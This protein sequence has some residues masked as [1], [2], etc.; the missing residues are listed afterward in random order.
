MIYKDDKVNEVLGKAIKTAVENGYM[1]DHLRADQSMYMLVDY[2]N[3]LYIEEMAADPES[4]IFDHDFAK[5][6][7]GIEPIDTLHL[8]SHQKT[9]EGEAVTLRNKLNWEWHLQ[10]MVLCEDPISYLAKFL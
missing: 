9:G 7:W 1:N 5:A 6:I 3:S 2:L 8:D 10:Q 4:L